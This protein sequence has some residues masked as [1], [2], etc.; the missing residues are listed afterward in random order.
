MKFHK[1]GYNKGKTVRRKMRQGSAGIRRVYVWNF[2][3]VI[4]GSDDE[5]TGSI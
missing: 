3:G 2:N 4:V 1:N 5:C